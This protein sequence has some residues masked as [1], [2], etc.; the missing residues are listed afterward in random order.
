[1][2]G[3]EGPVYF[4]PAIQMLLIS[5]ELFNIFRKSRSATGREAEVTCDFTE[6]RAESSCSFRE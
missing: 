1:M 3:L 6:L 2:L 4:Q 5:L